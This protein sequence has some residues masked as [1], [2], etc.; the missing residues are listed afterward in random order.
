MKQTAAVLGFA[1]ASACMTTPGTITPRVRPADR[2]R[3]ARYD[4]SF[5]KALETAASEY[6]STDFQVLDIA[7]EGEAGPSLDLSDTWSCR[8]IKI[9]GL[10]LLTAYAPFSC[11]IVQIEPNICDIEKTTGS[12]RFK[13]TL[14]YGGSRVLYRGV[15]YVTGRPAVNYATLSTHDQT[16]VESGQTVAQV[17]YFEHFKKIGPD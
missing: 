3:L 16:T 2:S 8:E 15:G 7:L 10:L 6:N 11:A 13:G 5:A 12:Q 17:G 4:T 1:C 14:Q 9:G